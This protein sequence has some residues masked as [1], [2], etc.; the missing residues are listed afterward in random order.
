MELIDKTPRMWIDGR[1][2]SGAA[3]ETFP[4]MNPASEEELAQVPQATAADVDRAAEAAHRA[5]EAGPWPRLRPRERARLLL[6]LAALVREHQETLARLETLNVGK[7]IRD[8]RDEVGMVADCFEYYAG[9]V[10][11]IYTEVKNVHV[12]LGEPP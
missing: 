6:R 12:T 2:A 7:P 10:T 5:F 3:G 8:S 1:E 9:A 4:V 11:R